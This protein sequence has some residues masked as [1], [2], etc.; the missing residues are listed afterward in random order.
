MLKCVNQ[1]VKTV[2]GKG[3]HMTIVLIERVKKDELIDWVER[4]SDEEWGSL[5]SSSSA[6]QSRVSSSPASLS[7]D[8]HWVTLCWCCVAL[9]LIITIQCYSACHNLTILYLH[10]CT[11]RVEQQW[12][13]D[14]ARVNT[15]VIITCQPCP[16]P[17]C[18]TYTQPF[19]PSPS[20]TTFH[21]SVHLHLQYCQGRNEENK[22]KCF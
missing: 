8:Q 9:T 3:V 20:P 4:D 6:L 5:S 14:Q 1:T 22:T 11:I 15:S 12:D 13:C 19:Q 10:L 2:G 17:S 7:P 16:T 21:L 18:L